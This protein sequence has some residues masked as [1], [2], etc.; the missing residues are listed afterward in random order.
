VIGTARL[1]QLRIPPGEHAQYN[2]LIKFIEN[3]SSAV[4]RPCTLELVMESFCNTGLVS[5]SD[6]SSK[7]AFLVRVRQV[8]QNV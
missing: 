4:A 6:L 7:F 3:Q 1:R 5:Y 8:V 2:N